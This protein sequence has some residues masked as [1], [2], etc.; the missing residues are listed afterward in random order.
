M[1]QNMVLKGIDYKTDNQS[2]YNIL[3]YYLTN[4]SA[5]NNIS[6]YSNENNGRKAY[7]ALRSTTKDLLILSYLKVKPAK[8]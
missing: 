7:K 4:T 8:C 3:H 2:L 6:K 5:W 1:K